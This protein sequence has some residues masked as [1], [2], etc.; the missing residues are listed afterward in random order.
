[1]ADRTILHCDMNNF[2][3][4]VELLSLPELAGKPVAV[5]G[6]PE[7]RHGIIL[8]KNY[9]AKAYGVVTAETIWQ[10]KRKCPG[11]IL[12]PP[13]YDR[14]SD[15]YKKINA[16]YARFTDLV[17]PFSIDESWLDVTGSRRL[18]GDGKTIA[19]TI[20][21]AVKSELGLTCS[22]GVS[23]NKI[24]AKMGSDYKKPDATTVITRE[25]YREILWPLPAR[26]LFGAGR[27]T[28][29]KLETIGIR[30][31]GDL[32]RADEKA[33]E[34]QFGKGGR[35]LWEYANGLE[36]SPVAHIDDRTKAKSIGNSTTYRRDLV[37]ETDIR[38]ALRALSD[39]VATRLRREHVKAGG[40][41]LDIRD[42][43]FKTISRQ[44]RLDRPTN[45]ASDINE[46][47][48]AVLRGNWP[49]NAPIRLLSVT[50]IYLEE[51]GEEA[52][53]ISMFEKPVETRVR[54]EQAERVVDAIRGR[55]GKSAIGYGR[56]V[57]ND[58]GLTGGR[59][60]RGPSFNVPDETDNN[61]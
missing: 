53:Q 20:R 29:E 7:N 37:S 43:Y 57:K 23:Y 24:F 61:E 55:F 52:V 60:D 19:D 1:M 34:K 14:Y 45:L 5:S 13:H 44:I 17:E 48:Y 49:E 41:K 46:A 42:P 2:F 6:D 28:A 31:I 21:A 32:A 33:L 22:V 11:L 38:T 12:I 54:D 4:S 27:K 18:F 35:M 15:F 40:L 16:I 36:N 3:A 26:E 30:T 50:G 59:R 9:E 58:L 10:A 56:L 25:N 47:A 51:E 8:A 39:Q